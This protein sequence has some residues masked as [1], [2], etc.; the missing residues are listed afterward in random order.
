MEHMQFYQELSISVI[1]L[2]VA[3][4]WKYLT[5][6][7]MDIFKSHAKCS[8][9]CPIFPTP[10]PKKREKNGKKNR[11]KRC[12]EKLYHVEKHNEIGNLR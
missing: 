2:L 9:R 1:H 7:L 4:S 5:I 11:R 10:I 8:L 12:V 6:N 3:Q